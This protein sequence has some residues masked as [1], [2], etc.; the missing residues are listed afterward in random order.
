MLYETIK[1][2]NTGIIHAVNGDYP[3]RIVPYSLCGLIGPYF[4]FWKVSRY[5]H[6]SMRDSMVTCKNCRTML[7]LLDGRK[8]NKPWTAKPYF[9]TIA[10]NK[11]SEIAHAVYLGKFTECGLIDK[12]FRNHILSDHNCRTVFERSVTCRSCRKVLGLGPLPKE[13]SKK[14]KWVANYLGDTEPLSIFGDVKFEIS[15]CREDYTNGRE[16]A[17]WYN[18]DKK[19]VI[20]DSDGYVIESEDDLKWMKQIV[21]AMAQGM[22][23]KGL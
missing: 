11:S 8:P 14:A 18:L 10:T 12:P 3:E 13:T 22:N 2:K 19:I 17:G 6:K 21:E 16:A 5:N 7:G 9:D 4:E 20:F 1:N 23:K 15:M